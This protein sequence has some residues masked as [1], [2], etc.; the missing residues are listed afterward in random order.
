M[1]ELLLPRE[2]RRR[3][4]ATLSFPRLLNIAE[5]QEIS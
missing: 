1:T 2:G 4:A 3:R 5:G